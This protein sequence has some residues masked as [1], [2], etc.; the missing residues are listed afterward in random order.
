[1]I[2]ALVLG[3]TAIGCADDDKHAPRTHQAPRTLASSAQELRR[4][5]SGVSHAVYWAGPMRGHRYE[6]TTL[7]DGSVFVRYLPR[8]VALADP[9]SLF[10]TVATYA[11][12]DAM[13][14][15]REGAKRPG[16]AVLRLGAGG[17]AVIHRARATSVFVAY[18]ESDVLIE[19][20]DRDPGR[21]RA[22]V[23]S[24]QLRRL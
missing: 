9:R 13:R 10:L 4:L 12:A 17:L 14:R 20:F 1:V 7:G 11:H 15:V 24:G 18:P 21:A 5:T 19:V 23:T 22:I 6:L 16:S 3:A 8:G 2:A